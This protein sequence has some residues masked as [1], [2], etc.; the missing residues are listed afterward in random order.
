MDQGGGHRERTERYQK[1]FC[2]CFCDD[3][4]KGRERESSMGQQ[5][6]RHWA[7]GEWWR[8]GRCRVAEFGRA[9]PDPAPQAFP[10]PDTHFGAT[11]PLAFF[12]VVQ[13]AAQLQS[14]TT[15]PSASASPRPTC[16]LV[17]DDKACVPGCPSPLL[18]WPDHGR[19]DGAGSHA[20]Q[21]L[22]KLL[23][24][25]TYYA[26]ASSSITHAPSTSS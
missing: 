16:L 22:A 13:P 20:L 7:N 21:L 1:I 14:T 12:S 19:P 15:A 2:F 18:W 23:A 9:A 26:S 24:A 6:G 5:A 3:K 17:L 10:E 8:G 25:A 4:L 11:H